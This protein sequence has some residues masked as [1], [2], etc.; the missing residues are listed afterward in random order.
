MAP[1]IDELRNTNKTLESIGGITA[2]LIK[3]PEFPWAKLFSAMSLIAS[4]FAICYSVWSGS[5]SFKAQQETQAYTYWQSFL[6]LTVQY[7][8][9]ANGMDSIDK[10]SIADISNF[11]R[12]TIRKHDSLHKVY[13]KYAWFVTNALGA[14]E[15]VWN[16][17]KGDTAWGNTLKQV[18]GFYTAFYKCKTFKLTDYSPDMRDLITTSIAADSIN[19]ANSRANPRTVSTIG[20]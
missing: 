2:K 3:K 4:I 8:E 1:I 15:I 14:A 9:F 5:V 18:L 7:P 17:Q 10:F 13:V 11:G 16:L 12:D 6:A 20:R 19:R